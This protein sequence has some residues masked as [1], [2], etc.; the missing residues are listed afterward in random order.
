MSTLTTEGFRLSPQQR[1][2]WLKQEAGTLNA[3]SLVLVEGSLS[4]DHLLQAV[5]LLLS[6]HEV[7]RT[8]FRRL[9]GVKVPFQVVLDVSEPG[10]ET[11]DLGDL[12]AGAQTRRLE[13][14]FRT[15][16]GYQFDLAQGPVLRVFLAQLSE[17][18]TALIVSLPALS[19]DLCALEILVRELGSLYAGQTESL[20]QEPLRYVQIAQWRNDLLE[21]DEGDALE[22]TNYW[23]EFGGR[24]VPNRALP[25]E[26]DG[27]QPFQLQS[28]TVV[29]PTDVLHKAEALAAKYDASCADLLLAVWQSFLWRL[30]GQETI[31]TRCFFDG[32]GHEELQ[33]APGLIGEFLPVPTKFG[34]D[35]RFRD[36]FESVRNTARKAAEWQEYFAPG[37]DAAGGPP[38]D[39]DY[40]EFPAA[41]SYGDLAFTIMR[42]EASC[43][44]F[45]A[46]LS[47]RRRGGMLALE[48]CFD[49]SRL[50]RDT[51]E[52]WN[53]YFQTMLA[54]AVENPEAPVS[55]LPLL[56]D[57]ERRKLLVEWNETTAEFAGQRCFHE[58]FEEQAS[59]TPDRE[60]VRYEDQYLSY[61]GLNEK[62]NQL[63]HFLRKNGVHPDALAGLCVERGTNLLAA[64]LAILKAGGA[65]VPVSPDHPQARLAQQLAPCTVLVTEQTF[66]ALLPGFAGQIIC[67]DRDKDQWE[68]EPLT[69]PEHTA[70]EEHLAYVIYTSGST[71]VPKGVAVRHRNLVNYSHSVSQKLEWNQYA[72]GL[73]F[74]TVSTLTADLGNTCI[75][76]SLISGGCVH[77]IGQDMSTES[78]RLSRYLREHPVDVLKIV[79]SHLA[80]LLDSGGDLDVLPRK[81]LVLGGEALTPQMIERIGALHPSCE[82]V[83]HYG[84]TETTVGSLVLRLRDYDWKKSSRRGIPI[85]RPTANTQ[86]YVLDQH[87]QPVPIGVAGELYIAGAGVAAGYLNQPERTA[88][89]FLP[90]PFGSGP[91]G[92]MYRTGDQARYLP[93]GNVEFLGRAD[94]QVKI[95]GYRVE[96]GE[97]ESVLAE[98]STVK[99]A[100]VL[101]REEAYGSR[102]LAA[103]V[104]PQRGQSVDA[105][106][107]R[108]YLRSRLPDYMIPSEI[109][110]LVRFPLTPNGKVDRKNL[111][112][113]HD[114]GEDLAREYLGART[115]A[116]ELI[117]GI[118]AEV[119]KRDRV[120]R[121]DNFFELGGHSLLGTLV[122]SRIREAFRIE[123]PLRVLFEAPTVEGL[124]ARAEGLQRDKQGFE[125]PP[126]QPVGRSGALPL[127]F[128]QQ[129]LWFLD[130]MEPG[131]S[132][133][134][135]PRAFRLAGALRAIAL[136][137]SLNEIV[138]RHESLRTRIGM[139]N[140]SPV[141][142]IDPWRKL[143][144]AVTDLGGV[145]APEREDAARRLVMEEAHRPFDLK[146]GPLFRAFLIR[147]ADDDHVFVM[148]TH[149]IVSDR[150]SAVV[151]MGELAALYEAFVAGKPS[152]L[153]E[154]TVQY[155]DWAVWQRKFLTG[156]QLE[157]ELAYWKKQLE[158]APPVLDLPTD[159]P[160]PAVET[161]RGAYQSIVVPVATLERLR[162]LSRQEGVTFFMTLLGAFSVLLSRYSRQQDIVIGSPI[163][164]RNHR[165]T[166]KLIG[167]FINTLVLR[168]SV[169]G[170]PTFRELLGRVSETAMGAYAHQELPF[171]KLVEELRPERDTSRN[172]LFQ[173]MLILQNTPVSGWKL[174]DTVASPFPVSSAT[175]KF[176]LTLAAIESAEGL[177]TTLKYNTDLFHE[178]TIQRMLDHW[179]VLLEA[180]GENPDLRCSE[181]PV[182][183]ARERRQTLVEWNATASEY[184]RNLCVHELIEQQA[185]R[186]PQATACCFADEQFTYRE[187]NERANQVAHDLR[188]RGVGP[189][190]RVA[191]LVE[192]S[193]AMVVGLVGIQKSGAAYVPLDPAYPA[194]RIR[195]TLEQGQ[196]TFV[197]T[198]EA[199]LGSLP[200]R[201]VEALCLDRDWKKIARNKRSNPT[202]AAGPEDS[203]Y[204]IFTSG[205]TG[206]PKGVEITHRNVVNLLTSMQRTP[207]LR[208]DDT[209]V[210]VTTLAFDIA[211]LELFLPLV[212]GAKVVIASRAQALDGKEL[213]R[214]LERWHA[215]VL[216]ATPASWLL[217]LE[218]GWTGNPRMKALCG[219]EA[220]SPEVARRLIPRCGELWNMYG[221]T[222]TTI[223]SSVY[224]VEEASSGTVPIGRPIANTSMYVLDAGRQPVPEGVAGDLYIGGDGVARQYWNQP[225]LTAEKFVPNLFVPG[226][227]I[228]HTGDMAKFLPDGN[229]QYLGRTD[230][231]VKV[232]GYRIEL[233]EIESVL[234]Q[235]PGIRE[236]AVAVREDVPGDRRLVAYVVAKNG[237]VP[238]SNALRAHLR[239]HLPEYMIPGAI[240]QLAEMPRT[241]N[242]KVDRHKLPPPDSAGT[243]DSA[244]ATPRDSVEIQLTELWKE[245]LGVSKIGIRDSFFDL[246]GHSLLV[247]SLLAEIE[248]VFGVSLPLA[249]LFHAKTVEQLAEVLRSRGFS[250]PW[251]S[252]VP[253]EPGGSRT[254][255]FCVHVQTG[256]VFFYQELAKHLGADQPVYGLQSVGLQDSR[257]PLVRVE[258]MAAHYITEIR[259]VQPE[260]PYLL[261][262]FCLGAYVAFEI[263]C[264]L[265]EQGQKVGM[266]AIFDTD[267]AWRK[268]KSL[269][270]GIG[271]HRRR[272]STQSTRKKLV[273]FVSRIRFRL[274]RAES[275]PK[276]FSIALLTRFRRNVP[277]R[278]RDFYINEL[279]IRANRNYVPRYFN[280]TITYFQ[281]T[282][283]LRQDPNY[284]WSDV[285]AGLELHSVP[286]TANGMFRKPHVQALAGALAAALEKAQTP[287]G[288]LV[289]VNEEA[290]HSE[291]AAYA[292]DAHVTV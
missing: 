71:G 33:N 174:V 49:G 277:N 134:N 213:G 281:G 180:V 143:T 271:Y 169:A 190:Q 194:E 151:L 69:N 206:R 133:Y 147:M 129:R 48:F 113:A 100:A 214:L 226:E 10:W 60:A 152:P 13:E 110:E 92:T 23:T 241:N 177:R 130:R 131:N 165:E 170:N 17:R 27:E 219:G 160:R 268:V 77:L 280:G 118:W 166:E 156:E 145:P 260:G 4:P 34:G 274:S 55:R 205:S 141:Q 186:T 261:G 275:V 72:E 81:Y 52:R 153:P 221:P 203:L 289:C 285:A 142:L 249:T 149:H 2:V 263:A 183:T 136:E 159:R 24:S 239:V 68:Q 62:A 7:L 246:G 74:A 96:L 8:V 5:R 28:H 146:T 140:G 278:F 120:G 79:P 254:P 89:R 111:P 173:V 250:S 53:G 95:R 216:Q 210:A 123:L 88:E 233:G 202:P 197:L 257:P 39:F 267:G 9:P 187:L 191:I 154:L 238:T 243:K 199:L 108:T 138:R 46:K 232:R 279:N 185:E 231:Q 251:S 70:N 230:Q 132:F 259:R 104:T 101:A 244:D 196:P 82:I 127:S 31:L 57:G 189:G 20:E 12:D 234:A 78:G 158:G 128:A 171:E 22:G 19:S 56:S 43:Q 245:I 218:A 67:L 11:M 107:L 181:A 91:N 38:I 184:P 98:H 99:Q 137:Q 255:F 178:A 195:L 288:G 220:L 58:L 258:E 236:A 264:Q 201:G 65:Y 247:V 59:H 273:Y 212:T 115:P 121:A 161:F 135:V 175:S 93:D 29:I 40:Q 253:M 75:F 47:A 76:P 276:R 14:L 90:N 256:N 122:V 252:L 284:F 225:G 105:G 235:S 242:G 217:L 21:T 125:T 148:N 291:T 124:A 176:D 66:L 240:V 117:A 168:T 114:Q 283:G 229:I 237:N 272:L 18:R 83:N 26:T 150:W 290:D 80:A 204:V 200:A 51:V 94:D 163:A 144:L 50:E 155:A 179:Q 1:R 287:A 224:R 266:L 139:S 15:S 32:R 211:A 102:R 208:A 119:L 116:E 215:T 45:K 269:A 54:G 126:V 44:P 61:R 172:P 270:D 3:V 25:Q 64:V 182:L 265:Q 109:I 157:R 209:L 162:A 16:R 164:G 188:A 6:R 35:T 112:V 103:Y 30:T 86:A 282:D 84:P 248:K 223:W 73:Q 87:R 41:T 63:A 207:G 198:E 85:G 37:E 228:Y 36:I 193:L 292:S 262:G 222:E 97:I 106:L 42:Q 167:F 227:R 192:R 286:G